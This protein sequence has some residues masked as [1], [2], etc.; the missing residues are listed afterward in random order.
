MPTSI[1]IAVVEHENR[2]LIGQRPAGVALA[3]LWEFPGGKIESGETAEAAAVRECLE[4]TG[5]AV[6]ALFQY[7]VQ[8]EQYDHGQ[9]ELHFIACAPLDDG[10]PNPAAGFRWVSRADLA[11]YEFPSGNRGLLQQLLA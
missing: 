5:I 4:E 1:A 10:R 6:E 3:G 11:N 7:R 8:I 9:V 2:F